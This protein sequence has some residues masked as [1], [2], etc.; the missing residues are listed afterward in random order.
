[1]SI[2]EKPERKLT[3]HCT[4]GD[5]KVNTLLTRKPCFITDLSPLT[6]NSL[7]Y[8]S[9]L[10]M[11]LTTCL[12]STSLRRANKAKNKPSLHDN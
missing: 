5:Y 12:F 7:A 2:P 9:L 11:S 1:M 6:L 8:A 4:S 3:D 10:S